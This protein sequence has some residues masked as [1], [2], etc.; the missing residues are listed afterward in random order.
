MANLSKAHFFDAGANSPPVRK[1][2]TMRNGKRVEE[3]IPSGVV[4]ELWVDK[5]GNECLIVMIE[6]GRPVTQQAVAAKRADMRALGFI[7]HHRCP[8]SQGTM[9][10]SDFPPALGRPCAEGSFGSLNPCAHVTHVVAERIGEQLA[11]RAA[12]DAEAN[13]E[14]IAREAA[15]NKRASQL[16]RQTEAVLDLARSVAAGQATSKK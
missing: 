14:A 13:A 10:A 11:K 2:I 3:R 8:L 4:K 7:E 15:E 1:V 6:R 5:R 9:F 16:E 12:R